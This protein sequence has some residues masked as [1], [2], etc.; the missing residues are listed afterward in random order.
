[1]TVLSHPDEWLRVDRT[2]SPGSP[3]LFVDRDGTLIENVPYLADPDHVRVIDGAVD[4]ILEFRAR[5]YAIIVV[6]NQ[7]GIAR[8]N[9]SVEQYR[10][11]EERVQK[12]LGEGA[13]DVVYACPFHPDGLVAFSRA[14]SSRKPAPGMLLDAARRFGIRLA[15]SVIVGDSLVD[16]QAGANAGVG[17]LIHVLTGH[18]RTDAAAVSNFA[19]TIDKAVETAV[20]IAKVD[21]TPPCQ[22]MASRR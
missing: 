15:T 20:T 10:A 11:V 14:H 12:L 6:S 13:A 22:S 3:A 5:G 1:M 17:R 18:G 19:A 4:T 21:P 16:M 8:G 9:C 2:P 7:S